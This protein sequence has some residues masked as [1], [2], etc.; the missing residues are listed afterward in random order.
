VHEVHEPDAVVL[1][2]AEEVRFVFALFSFAMLI[3]FSRFALALFSLSV[4]GGATVGSGRRRGV[5]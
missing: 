1:R 4:R 2:E 3:P 5:M